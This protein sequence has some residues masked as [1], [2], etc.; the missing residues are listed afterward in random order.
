MGRTARIE[1]EDQGAPSVDQQS[2]DG[3]IEVRVVQF[4]LY[5]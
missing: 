3:Q 5:A 1:H 4:D 2:V